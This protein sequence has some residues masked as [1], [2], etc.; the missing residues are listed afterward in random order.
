[1][2]VI[3]MKKLLSGFA[4]FLLCAAVSSCMSYA[5]ADG[6]MLPSFLTCIDEESFADCIEIEQV[7]IPQN[8]TEIGDE[9]FRGCSNMTRIVIPS[10]VSSI[11]YNAFDG[12]GMLVIYGEQN[13]AAESYALEHSIPFLPV[14]GDAADASCFTYE[15]P[16]E[17]PSSPA[18]P[19]Q[20]QSS[21]F[22]L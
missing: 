14:N 21:S 20:T 6:F 15:L 22:R 17:T 5:K 18:I 19:E 2:M 3:V 16:T 12:C 13:S 10:S 1:M 9:A 7:E 4:A 11:G 8:V